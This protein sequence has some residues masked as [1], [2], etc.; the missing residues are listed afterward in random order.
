MVS[1]L[2][3]QHERLAQEVEARFEQTDSGLKTLMGMVGQLLGQQANTTGAGAAASDE[4]AKAGVG[5]RRPDA[6]SPQKPTKVPRQGPSPGPISAA[7]ANSQ[8]SDQGQVGSDQ[9]EPVGID[10]GHP[11]TD[12]D[13]SDLNVGDSEQNKDTSADSTSMGSSTPS[14]TFNAGRSTSSPSH[15]TASTPTTTGGS[16]ER[17]GV[18]TG[19]QL[20]SVGPASS[21]APPL[22]DAC[23]GGTHGLHRPIAD[24]DL[25]LPVSPPI[26]ERPGS[27]SRVSVDEMDE[28]HLGPLPRTNP[29][30]ALSADSRSVLPSAGA[31]PIDA[32]PASG[33]D[34]PRS[35]AG[36][37]G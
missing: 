20:S 17:E 4:S 19:A 31:G 34:R 33:S 36:P 21:D 3:S 7:K 5:H 6:D 23:Y 11:V 22:G 28:S 14:S 18:Q 24:G 8:V 12:C 35:R 25:F 26:V 10:G 32:S 29:Q 13:A 16:A 37:H 27:Y 30:E 1:D 9:V 15:A 2:R